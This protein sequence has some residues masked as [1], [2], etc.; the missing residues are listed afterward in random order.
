MATKRKSRVTLTTG[1]VFEFAVLDG[2]LGY[3]VVILGGGTPYIAM[4]KSLHRDR[5]TFAELIRDE[6]ALVGQTMDAL[7]FHGRWTIVYRDFPI[8]AFIPFPNWKVGIRGILHTTDFEGANYWPMRLGEAE[9]LDYKFSRAPIAYQAA[10]EAIH[11]LAEWRDDYE[12]LTP[13]Y[14]ERRVTRV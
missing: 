11:G 7:F 10:L 12:K 6:I 8:P 2:R 13:A 5:P 1:D 9:L 14:A 3:G 4:L